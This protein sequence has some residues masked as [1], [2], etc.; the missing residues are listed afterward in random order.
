MI[1]PAMRAYQA[2][3]ETAISGRE[4]DAACFRLL[5]VELEKARDTTDP[6]IRS[7]VLDKHQKMWGIIMKA[8][9]S[10]TGAATPLE[11][12]ELFIR[13]ADQAQRYGIKLLVDPSLSFD[14]LIDI[15]QNVLEGLEASSVV[16]SDM[17]YGAL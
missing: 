11:D 3:S 16:E 7:A 5:L 6:V 4:A 12:R 17:S 9:I 2:V 1:H 8:N 14:P 10:E 13:L 15:A